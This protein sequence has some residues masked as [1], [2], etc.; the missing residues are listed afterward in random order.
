MSTTGF[1]FVRDKSVLYK[2]IYGAGGLREA[3]RGRGAWAEGPGAMFVQGLPT[4]SR[5]GSCCWTWFVCPF[6]NG[7]MDHLT[8]AE[9]VCLEQS[10]RNL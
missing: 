10:L 7:W 4:T 1:D 3:G 2:S 9:L 5:F 6:H 8:V